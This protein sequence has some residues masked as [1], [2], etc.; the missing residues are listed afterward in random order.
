MN[1]E[2]LELEL[3]KAKAKLALAKTKVDD[4]KQRGVD[5]YAEVKSSMTSLDFNKDL[6]ESKEQA[7]NELEVKSEASVKDVQDLESKIIELEGSI[8]AK[9]DLLVNTITDK[10]KNERSGSKMTNTKEAKLVAQFYENTLSK[11]AALPIDVRSEYTDGITTD[12][13]KLI[14][15]EGKF[16]RYLPDE[17]IDLSSYFTGEKVDSATGQIILNPY[18]DLRLKEVGQ[19]Q[20]TPELE[21]D[22]FLELT[23]TIKEFAGMLPVSKLMQKVASASVDALEYY[24]KQLAIA[25]TNTKNDKYVEQFK[26]FTPR[27]ITGVADLRNLINTGVKVKLKKR[28]FVTRSLYAELDGETYADGRLLSGTDL[29]KASLE[30]IKGVEIIVVDDEDFGETGDKVGFFGA[31][32]ALHLVDIGSATTSW[33]DKLYRGKIAAADTAF[34]LIK[35]LPNEGYWLTFA[36]D[37]TPEDPEI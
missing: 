28:L 37:V 31:S 35:V 19:L 23:Y 7:F 21:V 20:K 15:N 34:D 3:R 29:A 33:D 30:S 27:T 26:T 11:G 10:N 17:V 8:Q 25:I 24:Y 22:K 18:M 36:E 4:I 5:L 2:Q 13:N 9:K 14:V 32:T 6:L 1:V 12:G 16:V